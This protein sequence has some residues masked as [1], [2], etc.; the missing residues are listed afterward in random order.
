MWRCPGLLK[1]PDRDVYSA[2]EVVA[3]ECISRDRP[4]KCYSGPPRLFWQTC[5]PGASIRALSARASVGARKAAS[6][7]GSRT[8]AWNDL[9]AH[10]DPN[11][12][13]QAYYA[14]P[15]VLRVMLKPFS[16]QVFDTIW[17]AEGSDMTRGL[18]RS[19]LVSGLVEDLIHGL[20]LTEIS[21]EPHEVGSWFVHSGVTHYRSTGMTTSEA[22]IRIYN[23]SE[24]TG[25]VRKECR[26]TSSAMVNMEG[27]DDVSFV[28]GRLIAPSKFD[29]VAAGY[30]DPWASLASEATEQSL[31]EIAMLPGSVPWSAN[32]SRMCFNGLTDEDTLRGSIMDTVERFSNAISKQGAWR[33]LYDEKQKARHERHHQG[34]FRLFSQL[35]FGALGIHVEPN[36][37]HGSGSTD[38]TLRLNESVNIIEFKKDDKLEEIRHGLSIQ[39][40]NYMA[41]AGAKYGTYV[42]MCHHRPAAEVERLFGNALSSDPSLPVIDC[43]AVDCSWKESA[44]RAEMRI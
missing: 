16:Q 38:F 35:A 44:S 2:A 7:K 40:P 42:V 36:A 41:S 21:E 6:T 20:G 17:D 25:Q 4:S 37:D 34:L 14:R 28:V 22:K 23:N 39:L 32:L 31:A 5:R 10:L 19:G 12:G 33:L 30:R 11:L 24:I 3:A 29:L 18:R 1:L 27:D 15:N 43:Y 9:P 26:I 13:F 8:M